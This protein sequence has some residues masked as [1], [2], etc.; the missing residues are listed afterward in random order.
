MTPLHPQTAVRIPKT[1]DD[2]RLDTTALDSGSGSYHYRLMLD[3][4][5]EVLWDLLNDDLLRVLLAPPAVPSF[6]ADT[7]PPP[8]R[9]GDS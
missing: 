3:A 7:V 9:R 1:R 2:S 4:D 8:A 6:L 5:D